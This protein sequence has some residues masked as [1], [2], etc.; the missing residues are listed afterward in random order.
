MTQRSKV[1]LTGPCSSECLCCWQ[2]NG[3]SLKENVYMSSWALCH[4]THL[5]SNWSAMASRN[6]FGVIAA[7]ISSL[8]CQDFNLTHRD[9]LGLIGLPCFC[10]FYEKCTTNFDP[11]SH[12]LIVSSLV[13]VNVIVLSNNHLIVTNLQVWK[14]LGLSGPDWPFVWG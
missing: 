12:V 1:G 5:L 2:P 11:Y 10:T 9:N 6:I 8:I 3:T 7:T 14:D 13:F 4:K